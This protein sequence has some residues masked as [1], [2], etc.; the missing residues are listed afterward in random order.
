[1]GHA[2]VSFLALS[3]PDSSPLNGNSSP[4]NQVSCFAHQQY[5]PHRTPASILIVPSRL[6]TAWPSVVQPQRQ[7]HVVSRSCLQTAWPSVL[8]KRPLLFVQKTANQAKGALPDKKATLT[9]VKRGFSF[10]TTHQIRCP[11]A[12]SYIGVVF[13]RKSR[14]CQGRLLHT[15]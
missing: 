7:L 8:P 11:L 4:L 15:L 1:M 9:A 12:L 5:S 13:V 2:I 14:I 3:L 6:Q 10:I